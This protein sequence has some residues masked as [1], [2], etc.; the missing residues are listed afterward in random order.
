[1]NPVNYTLAVDGQAVAR[2]SNTEQF[3]LSN[4][5]T[6]QDYRAAFAQAVGTTGTISKVTQMAFGVGGEADIQGNPLPPSDNGP[7][8]EIVLTKDISEVSYPV[9]TTVKFRAVINKGELESAAINEV[10]LI[11]ADGTTVAKM[12]CLTSKG[13]DAESGGIFDFS[14]EF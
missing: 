5:K 10:A 14:M 3:F 4:K 11:A 2:S 13:I 12:R 8:N 7:L 1:M 9:S 6:T